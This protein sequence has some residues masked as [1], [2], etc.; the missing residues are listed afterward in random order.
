MGHLVLLHDG[1]REAAILAAVTIKQFQ[2]L[3]VLPP[4]MEAALLPRGKLFAALR[5][6][7]LIRPT[8]RHT[9]DLQVD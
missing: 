9:M 3:A 6:F 5:T 2:I 1:G 7:M 4:Q 8:V